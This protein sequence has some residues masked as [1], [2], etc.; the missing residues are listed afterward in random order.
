M[1]CIVT[2]AVNLPCSQTIVLSQSNQCQNCLHTCLL[3]LCCVVHAIL[4]FI[5]LCM[6]LSV[7]LKT[8]CILGTCS[9]TEL[10][11]CLSQLHLS[12]HPPILGIECR[13]SCVVGKCSVLGY[14]PCCPAWFYN[15]NSVQSRVSW[16][17]RSS[18]KELSSSD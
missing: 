5:T 17:E 2:C 16:E 12:P 11:S 4:C 14:N 1:A 10:Y 15:A 18:V 6:M 3:H 13:S 8:L 7:D 9:T